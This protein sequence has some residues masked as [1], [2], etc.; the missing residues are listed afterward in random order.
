MPCCEISEEPLLA[1]DCREI[2]VREL[3]VRCLRGDDGAIAALIERFQGRIYGLCYRM[4]GHRHDAED[5][6]QETFVRAVRSLAQWDATREFS[7]WLSAIAANRCRTMMER[8]AK[9]KTATGDVELAADD[10]PDRHAALQLAEEVQRAL[11][12]LR[13]DYRQAFLLFHVDQLSYADIGA[14]LE[15][16]LGTVKTWVHR[17]RLELAA[18]LRERGVVEGETDAVR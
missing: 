14:A 5:A 10:R 16:P 11:G 8:R 15:V 17:A 3:V 1:D 12:G 13:E 2:E 18:A 6:V 4:L 9:R 7:P